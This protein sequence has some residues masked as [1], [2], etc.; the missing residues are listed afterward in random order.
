MMDRFGWMQVPPVLDRP[1]IGKDSRE[2]SEEEFVEPRVVIYG[3]SNL[4][5]LPKLQ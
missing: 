4:S 1:F 5:K 2:Y 3:N